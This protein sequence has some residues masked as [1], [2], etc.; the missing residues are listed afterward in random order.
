[1][2]S[3]EWN[4]QTKSRT[5]SKN[6]EKPMVVRGLGGDGLDKMGKGKWEVQA[7]SYGINK[8]WEWEIQHMEYSR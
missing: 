4:K 1:M 6:T 2:E 5:R 3:K 7:S 8:S